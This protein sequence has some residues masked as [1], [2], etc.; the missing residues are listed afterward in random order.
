[1]T[2]RHYYRCTDC[3]SV[4]A[5][6]QKLP[7]ET[8]HYTERVTAE[9][10]A[11]GGSIEYMGPVVRDRLVTD[12]KYL[13]PCDERCTGARGPNCD[14]SCGGANHGTGAM[15]EVVVTSGVPRLMIR[16]EARTWTPQRGQLA[17]ME[18]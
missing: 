4:A 3:L 1:M 16:P 9:C 7:T 13:C 2:L 8:K 10:G 12:V 17:L 6:E 14:C 15:A 11:C 18:A 5:T